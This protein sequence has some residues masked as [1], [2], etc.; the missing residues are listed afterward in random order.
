[1]TALTSSAQEPELGEEEEELAVVV[2][3]DMGLLQILPARNRN[4]RWRFVVSKSV[5]SCFGPSNYR[6]T[7]GHFDMDMD[8]S[9]F[10]IEISITCKVN[11]R[12]SV[13]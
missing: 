5:S 2:R 1:V 13:R 10:L 6:S 9:V 11:A 12:S 7:S 8:I 3:Q 4:E